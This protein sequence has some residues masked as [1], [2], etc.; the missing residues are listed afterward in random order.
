MKINIE[1]KNGVSHNIDGYVRK[2]LE[3][4]ARYI[5][6]D[7]LLRIVV[8]LQKG[9][10]LTELTLEGEGP[11]FHSSS[12]S[13]NIKLSVDEG[14]KKLIY[15]LKKFREKLADHNKEQHPSEMFA[16]PIKEEII[17]AIRKRKISCSILSIDKAIEEFSSLH[18]PFF[19]FI[20]EETG[21]QNIVY[22]EKEGVYSLIEL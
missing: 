13:S 5:K 12:S 20:N 1:L 22:K 21:K 17:P 8:S 2:K 14:T 19:V 6:N 15:Q 11:I 10:F 16:P 18:Q 7:S 4:L 3:K 9:R